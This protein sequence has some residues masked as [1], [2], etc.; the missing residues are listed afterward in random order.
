MT[1]PP[2]LFFAALWGLYESAVAMVD[3][4]G[5]TERYPSLE[6]YEF[7]MLPTSDGHDVYWEAVGNPKGTPAVYLHGGPGSGC[8]HGASSNFDPNAYRAV[9]FDH[10]W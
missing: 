7:G 6:P 1:V 3:S 9:L 2:A 5:I 8:T 10:R 4:C